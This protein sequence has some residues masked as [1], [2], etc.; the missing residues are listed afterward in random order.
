MYSSSSSPPPRVKTNKQNKHPP[1]P[2]IL[3]KQETNNNDFSSQD[4]F[5]N[6]FKSN[7]KRQPFECYATYICSDAS[8]A[9][10]VHKNS[11]M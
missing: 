8:R 11:C 1:P 6:V 7:W 10:D 4:S 3:C 2:P 5:P 9:N